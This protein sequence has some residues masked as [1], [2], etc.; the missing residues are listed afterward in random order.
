MHG[1]CWLELVMNWWV[2]W[3]HNSPPLIWLGG[4]QSNA[5]DCERDIDLFAATSQVSE[6]ICFA[7]LLTS[8]FQDHFEQVKQY[9]NRNSGPLPPGSIQQSLELSWAHWMI[10]GSHRHSCPNA[11]H[12]PQSVFVRVLGSSC[13]VYWTCNICHW[14]EQPP[15]CIQLSSLSLM[16]LSD[17]LWLTW[18]PCFCQL[19]RGFIS[20][21]N[22]LC[23]IGLLHPGP[24]S[25]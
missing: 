25:Y 11:P 9:Q 4:T 18:K 3:T 8:H 17:R 10:L 6:L 22:L 20:F 12:L 15:I 21:M 1:P 5:N 2:F 13:F 23:S 14:C 16:R 24:L 19:V 7:V